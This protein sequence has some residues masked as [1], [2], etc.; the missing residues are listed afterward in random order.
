M[1]DQWALQ[2]NE[3]RLSKPL[4]IGGKNIH[5]P[6]LAVDLSENL[7][8][9]YS[10]RDLRGDCIKV[11]HYAESAGQK[12]YLCSSINGIEFQPTIS[13][14]SSRSVVIV[15]VAH[16]E[17]EWQLISRVIEN[18]QL[19]PEEVLFTNEEGI[20]HPRLLGNSDGR[21]WVIFETIVNKI[22]QLTICFYEKRRWSDVSFLPTIKDVAIYRPNLAFGPDKSIWTSYD[23]YMDG[24]YQVFIQRIDEKSLPIK[25]TDNKYQNLYNSIC[26]DVDN[27]LWIAWASNRNGSMR[28]RW[29]LTKWNYLRRF[30]GTSFSDPVGDSPDKDIYSEDPFQGWEFPSVI[31]DTSQRIWIF[32]QSSHTL[33]AQYYGGHEWSSLFVIDQKKWGS[34]K[35]RCRAVTASMGIYLASMGLDGGQ[36]QKIEIETKESRNLVSKPREPSSAIIKS[37]QKKITPTL[38]SSS[39]KSLG[40]FFGDLHFHS[41]YGDAVGDIDEL[42]YRYRDGY[43][44]DFA[45]LTEHDYLDGMELSLSE[46]KMISNCA[47][48][49]NTLGEFV[50]FSA[51]EWTAPA[52]I[53]HT[54]QGQKVGEGHKNVYFPDEKFELFPYGS[55]SGKSGSRLLDSLRGKDVLVIPHHTG[56]SGIHW[57]DH[58]ENL[59]R[60]IEVCSIHGRFEY[61]GNLPIGHRRDHVHLGE[62]VIDGLNRGYKLGFVGGSD[63]H[64]LKWHHTELE[65]RESSHI[66]V[67]TR[68]GWKRDAYRAGMTAIIAPELS[69]QAL[70]NALKQRRC[71]ATSG[72]RIFLDFRINNRLM[73]SEFVINDNPDILVH[74]QGTAPIRSVEIVRSGYVFSGFQS[75]PGEGL[76]SVSY[77]MVDNIISPSESHYYYLRV[78]Q[79]DGNMAWSSPIWVS[80]D[81]EFHP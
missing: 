78:I 40:V 77:R 54:V 8:V 47:T 32:G 29:W 4:L 72:V 23:V 11:R 52:I 59:Q 3:F 9:V 34:W 35:P 26:T 53:E 64:G 76:L 1:F 41:T 70:F 46:M 36:L 15:W 66:P 5:E 50:T 12:T 20:F 13:T 58:D 74:V 19:G 68:V 62:F 61:P 6:D 51:Y 2:E 33:F 10:E 39:G 60:L 57:E 56:W 67:G 30:D 27:N 21:A 80:Y 71:Y 18:D 25:V 16:R 24:N 81:P 42:Y 44:Y 31:S 75:L 49:M 43:G 14:I 55:E 28:D 73:G 45:S 79:E 7:W 37:Q 69:R 48:Q 17:G 65:G 63:S 38:I 22:P